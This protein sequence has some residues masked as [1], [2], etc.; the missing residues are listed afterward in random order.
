MVAARTARKGRRVPRRVIERRED[1][2]DEGPQ[3]FFDAGADREEEVAEEDEIEDEV[4]EEESPGDEE[5][6]ARSAKAADGK[7]KRERF[8]S[9]IKPRLGRA[10]KSIALVG[11][12]GRRASYEY[13]QR[14]AEQVIELLEKAIA[15]V[16]EEFADKKA[17]MDVDLSFDD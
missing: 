5:E 1:V 11:R 12:C 8:K 15:R 14:E 3:D 13:S 10:L 4:E 6:E 16:R 9:L 2:E 17:E 7:T